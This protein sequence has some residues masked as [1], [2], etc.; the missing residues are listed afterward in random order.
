MDMWQPVS[1]DTP[2]ARALVQ[3]MSYHQIVLGGMRDAPRLE[4]GAAVTVLGNL[5]GYLGSQD[6]EPFPSTRRALGLQGRAADDDRSAP[7][8]TGLLPSTSPVRAAAERGAWD[9]LAAWQPTSVLE[10]T[11]LAPHVEGDRAAYRQAWSRLQAGDHE[12]PVR[13]LTGEAASFVE[14]SDYALSADPAAARGSRADE[15]DVRAV[16]D[17]VQGFSAP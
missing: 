16:A 15:A 12:G 10:G 9:A 17:L 1:D 11:I 14:L 3:L 13:P 8:T 6:E 7:G 4:Q 5:A 2:S